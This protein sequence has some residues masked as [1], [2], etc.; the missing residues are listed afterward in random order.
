MAS[1][2]E[3]EDAFGRL[4]RT[5]D[6]VDPTLRARHVPTRRIACRIKDLDIV[7]S[8]K[9]DEDGV[10]DLM[11]TSPSGAVPEDA[12]VKVVV[13][14]DDLVALSTGEE[15]FLQAWLRGRVQISAPMRDVLRLRSLVGL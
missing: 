5:L 10:H 1:V 6:G 9:L 7:Y 2:K 13:T 15:D 11:A 3:C 14:S 4:S 12:E 8:A